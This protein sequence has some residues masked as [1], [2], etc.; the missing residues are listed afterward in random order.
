M[1]KP[2]DAW[3]TLKKELEAREKPP[4]FKEREVWFAAVG[5]NIG[6]EEDGK[7]DQY[8]RPVLVVKRFNRNLFFGVAFSSVLKEENRFYHTVQLKGKSRSVILSQTRVYSAK[9]LLRRIAFLDAAEFETVKCLTAYMLFSAK[10]IKTDPGEPESS[11]PEGIC[12]TS[13]AKSGKE[14]NNRRQQ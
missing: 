3:N 1:D 5:V 6:H 12:T 2:F 4:Y 11:G 8:E 7:N 9:R 14:V 10:M 13:V